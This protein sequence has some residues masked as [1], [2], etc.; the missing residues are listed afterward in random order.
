M[1]KETVIKTLETEVYITDDGMIFEDESEA[2]GWEAKIH[3]EKIIKPK[4][5]TDIRGNIYVVI[6]SYEEYNFYRK[7]HL[8]FECNDFE[9]SDYLCDHLV[10]TTYP[11]LLKYDIDC[12]VSIVGADEYEFYKK[13]CEMYEE[14]MKIKEPIAK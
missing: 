11:V 6:D 13:I 12:E 7:Y 1:K 2:V 3:Y 5:Y 8:E 14:T 10:S 9:E 4:E